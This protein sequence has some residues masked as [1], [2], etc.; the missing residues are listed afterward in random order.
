LESNMQ[1][2]ETAAALPWEEEME[3]DEPEK[4]SSEPETSGRRVELSVD[5]HRVSEGESENED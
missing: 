2:E 1:D 4:P 3:V 5:P